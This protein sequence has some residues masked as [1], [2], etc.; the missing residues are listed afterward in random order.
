M[1][2]DLEHKD[3]LQASL[4]IQNLKLPFFLHCPI[5]IKLRNWT[6][7]VT[8]KKCRQIYNT[9]NICYHKCGIMM[10]F[11][12]IWTEA[13]ARWYAPIIYSWV[14]IYVG[15]IFL[16]EHN[17]GAQL[18]SA[19]TPTNSVSSPHCW[20]NRSHIPL[21]HIIWLCVPQLTLIIYGLQWVA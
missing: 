4:E 6:S 10:R 16:K 20:C 8:Y 11:H 9:S 21:Q 14:N 1:Y 12:L 18:S 13:G 5:K 19:P 17:F 7:Q 2:R 15:A 3:T